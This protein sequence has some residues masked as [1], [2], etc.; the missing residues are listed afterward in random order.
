MIIYNA[1]YDPYHLDN[2]GCMDVTKEGIIVRDLYV[3]KSNS[4]KYTYSYDSGYNNS[5]DEFE[6]IGES[7]NEIITYSKF[8]KE[9]RV[10][11]LLSEI[12]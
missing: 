2:Y 8:L 10:R 4:T 3:W 7:I 6:L 5:P 12:K 1:C 9:K 11:Q